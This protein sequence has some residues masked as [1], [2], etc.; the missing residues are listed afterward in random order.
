MQLGPVV[1][2]TDDSST[3]IWIQ[4]S[5]EPARYKLRVEGVKTGRIKAL[6]MPGQIAE[7]AALGIL[8]EAEAAL[9]LDEYL[10]VSELAAYSTVT[11]LIL[12]LNQTI[13]KE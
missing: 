8:T 6:D 4:V 5:D 2:H 13:V 7:G 11:S 12:N 9:L 10:D 3:R 1:G